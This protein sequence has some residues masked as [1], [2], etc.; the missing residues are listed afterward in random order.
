MGCATRIW[1]S[2][3]RT[4]WTLWSVLAVR[5][6]SEPLLLST[7][8][9]LTCNTAPSCSS[10]RPLMDAGPHAGLHRPSHIH[11]CR[12]VQGARRSSL[13]QAAA[14]AAGAA[15]GRTRPD[16]R[17]A[18]PGEPGEGALIRARRHQGPG[19]RAEHELFHAA[20]PGA[21]PV[22]D[23]HKVRPG[24]RAAPPAP[25]APRRAWFVRQASAEA[26]GARLAGAAISRAS[27]SSS[28]G[29]PARLRS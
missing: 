29:A 5:A 12:A 15:S 20:Q 14:A 25:A 13:R 9:L 27:K 22:D 18:R 8:Y 24:P 1:W 21:L 6:S 17:A 16:R 19:D 7:T 23:A 28:S 10:K 26:G 4:V 3:R 2:W 11:V